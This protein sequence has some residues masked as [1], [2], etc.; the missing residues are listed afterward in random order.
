MTLSKHF[1][2][3]DA[4][5]TPDELAATIKSYAGHPS[6]FRLADGR[7]PFATFYP[8]RSAANGGKPLSWWKLLFQKL[9]VIFIR[10]VDNVSVLV[11][12]G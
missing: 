3:K 12:L 1:F 10:S 8:E 4:A 6:V 7:L 5:A 2:L 11:T 9:Q